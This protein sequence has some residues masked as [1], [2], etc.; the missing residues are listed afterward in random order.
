MKST[1]RHAHSRSRSR[2]LS[3][4]SSLTGLSFSSSTNS[5]KHMS[6]TSPPSPTLPLPPAVITA[7]A[8]KR[9][10]H[11]RR[12][13]SVSTR[14]ESADMMGV[15]VTDLPLSLS[16][17]NI[18]LGDKDSLRRRALWALEGKSDHNSVSKVEIPDI[19]TPEINK[20][21]EIRKC[22]RSFS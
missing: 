13:S 3:V 18:N 20:K 2:N 16:D 19:S 22:I 17:D 15:P 9:N 21:F 14:H 11:H 6:E 7:P 4:S 1:Y 10:S 8:S 5:I 12:R